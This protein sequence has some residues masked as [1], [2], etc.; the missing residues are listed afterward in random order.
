MEML[1][2]ARYTKI[3]RMVHWIIIF[4]YDM[5]LEAENDHNDR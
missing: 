3:P 5:N 2:K 1:P 4:T